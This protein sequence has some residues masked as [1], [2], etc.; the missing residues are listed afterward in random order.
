MMHPKVRAILRALAQ[1]NVRYSLQ[2]SEADP[3]TSSGTTSLLVER[4]QVR[5]AVHILRGLGFIRLPAPDGHD[6]VF[7]V[8]YDPPTA[9]W[10]RLQII[11]GGPQPPVRRFVPPAGIRRLLTAAIPVRRRGLSV[12]LLGP[13]GAGKTT[14]AAGIGRSFYFPVRLLY[15]GLWQGGSTPP[16]LSYLPGAELAAR[17]LRAWRPYLVGRYHRA[18]GRLV[19]FDRYT[20]D[21]LL[22]APL[23]SDLRS[24]LYY[25]VLGH[26]CPAP[27]LVLVL[28]VP[29]RI[30]YE[31]KGE[32][33]PEKLEIQ[34]QRF[35]AISKQLRHVAVLDGTLPPEQVCNR[36]VARI[37]LR[38]TSGK[39]E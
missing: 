31:R 5:R 18:C 2:G 3:D 14:L 26:A 38:Y 36:A 8:A 12:A 4:R 30:M 20:Y 9:R 1:A 39:L 25:W 13:D 16:R 27:D 10:I 33:S 7:F 15:M 11:A 6:G 28:D 35:L 19:I 22:S 29:G 24:R 37:W 21:A 23:H 17:L 34:R 32:H